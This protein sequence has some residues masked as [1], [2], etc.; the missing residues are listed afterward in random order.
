MKMVIGGPERMAFHFPKM[1]S[2]KYARSWS[3]LAMTEQVCGE[4]WNRCLQ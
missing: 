1:T 3:V 2:L 4:F